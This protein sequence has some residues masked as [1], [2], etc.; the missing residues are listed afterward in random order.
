MKNKLYIIPGHGQTTRL[1]PYQ[2]IFKHASKKYDVVM[3]NPKWKRSLS[4]Q[5]FLTTKN[6][7]I[8]GFSLGALLAYMVAQKYPHKKV[9]AASMSPILELPDK[10]IRQLGKKKYLDFKKFKYG[11]VKV[12]SL[13]G[14][15][16]IN[17]IKKNNKKLKG[18]VIPD[19]GHELTK[20]YIKSIYKLL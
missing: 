6:D 2:E 20:Q 19:T 10:I 16:E 8:F 18:L 17:E 11:G 4:S 3:I 15:F 9:I 14:E 13:C 5:I 1:K 7:I 12:V